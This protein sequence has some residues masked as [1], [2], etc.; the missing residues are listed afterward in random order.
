MNE[1]SKL[2]SLLTVFTATFGLIRSIVF[3]IVA[4]IILYV[5]GVYFFVIYDCDET[6]LRN[7]IVSQQ[8]VTQVTYDVLLQQKDTI[9]RKDFLN[10]QKKLIEYK[11]DYDNLRGTWL[12]SFLLSNRPHVDIIIITS[13]ESKKV[14]KDD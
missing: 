10:E 13:E 6:K 5:C 14:Y 1:I 8:K 11:C 2:K 4:V 12:G 7:R 3:A 9:S